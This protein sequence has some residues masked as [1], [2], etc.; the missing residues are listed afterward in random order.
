MLEE[1]SKALTK[2]DVELRIGSTNAK[3]FSLL[4]Y[5]TARTDVKR[6][7]EVCGVNWSNKHFYDDKG[8]LCCSISVY[9]KETNQWIERIDVGTE[10]F[11]EKEK[12]SYSDSFKRAGF[13]WGIGLELYNSP[14]I[15]I[16]WDM[17]QKQNGKGYDPIKF[18]SSNLDIVKYQVA[19]GKVYLQIAYQNK[20]IFDNLNNVPMG[21]IK[22]QETYKT[23]SKQSDDEW[24]EYWKEFAATCRGENIAPN[25]FIKE[26]IKIDILDKKAVQGAVAKYLKDKDMFKDQLENYKHFKKN[27]ENSN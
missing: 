23:P 13:R 2:D 8:L 22:P 17:K 14:F 19:N 27:N 16:A 1:L 20:V 26:W 18:F 5:K 4:L 6:F 24:G 10:S 21:D 15:W 25:D 12:G 11:T 3:G 9:D 7:N